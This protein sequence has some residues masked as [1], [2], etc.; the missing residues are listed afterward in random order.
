MAILVLLIL[1]FPLLLL[2][3]KTLFLLL[4]GAFAIVLAWGW[5]SLMYR[6]TIDLEMRGDLQR[7]SRRLATIAVLPLAFRFRG[8]ADNRLT[9]KYLLP[10]DKVSRPR[11]WFIVLGTLSLLILVLCANSLCTRINV[12]HITRK[13]MVAY[14]KVNYYLGKA[15][16][17]TVARAVQTT[18]DDAIEAVKWLHKSGEFTNDLALYQ[19][20][21]DTTTL[22]GGDQ[23]QVQDWM[24]RAAVA[25]VSKKDLCFAVARGCLFRGDPAKAEEWLRKSGAFRSNVALYEAAMRFCNNIGDEIQAQYWRFKAFNA[26]L[27]AKGV[28]RGLLQDPMLW[29]MKA[30][31]HKT[32]NTNAAKEK[33]K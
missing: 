18:G 25:G 16:A 13:A 19:Y 1:S 27:D 24:E 26:D 12:D 2:I 11:R 7:A 15:S 3:G 31:A 29:Y 14:V 5:P 4:W 22:S 8:V 21:I 17:Q 30:L 9:E 33:K 6:K 20:A 10:P 23:K 28:R 32:L